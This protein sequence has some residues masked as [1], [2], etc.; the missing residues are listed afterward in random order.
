MASASAGNTLAVSVARQ[1]QG[2]FVQQL[3]VG[4]LQARAQ[5]GHGARSRACTKLEG[6]AEAEVTLV[7]WGSTWGVLAEA[8][9]RLNQERNSANH[10][11]I[12]LLIPSM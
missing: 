9:E 3:S 8:V 6:P 1:D 11:Q 7:G 5:D 2:V 10:L 4:D 12:S